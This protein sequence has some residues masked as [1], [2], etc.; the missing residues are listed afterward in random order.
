[1]VHSYPRGGRR[2]YGG[3]FSEACVK[4]LRSVGGKAEFAASAR[5]GGNN[6]LMESI[7]ARTIKPSCFHAS[8]SPWKSLKTAISPFSHRTTTRFTLA[9]LFGRA[10]MSFLSG[11]DIE[12]LLTCL[13]DDGRSE[14][15]CSVPEVLLARRALYAPFRICSLQILLATRETDSRL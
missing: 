8:H 6:G 3:R 5:S 10:P 14:T 1:M 9:F 4:D 13:R 12:A 11:S 2:H 15:V 7:E